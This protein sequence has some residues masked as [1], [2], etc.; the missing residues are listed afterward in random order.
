MVDSIVPGRKGRA[1]SETCLFCDEAAMFFEFS[2][3]SQIVL[4]FEQLFVEPDLLL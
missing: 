3:P 1:I 2:N 4:I